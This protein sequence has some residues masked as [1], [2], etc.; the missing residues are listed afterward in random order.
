[1]SGPGAL[2]ERFL[3]DGYLSV[4]NLDGLSAWL[5]SVSPAALEAEQSEDLAQWYRLNDTWFAGVN[6][7]PNDAR[8]RV[9][10]G[11]ALPE[12]VFALSERWY[13]RLPLDRAQISVT[14]PG[15]PG[16]GDAPEAAHRY[17]LHR[18]SAHVDGLHA[19]G[20]A[21]ARMLREPHA[22]VLGIPLSDADVQASP[23]VVWRGSHQVMR[24]ALEP[25]LSDVPEARWAD[26]DLSHPYQAARRR[27]FETCDAE[28]V[29]VPRG[30]A[31]LVHRHALHGVK[32]WASAQT[33]PRR[34]LYFRPEVRQWS[35]WL[36]AP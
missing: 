14:Y 21:R 11:L 32:P 24:A 18:F 26:V 6:A 2:A 3:R 13:G 31:Y 23:M 8:G 9:G 29:H 20:P 28:V 34:I 12:T 7:L 10:D 33:M 25:A 5:D 19:E 35:D 4:D 16:R 27:V 17:R 36:S 1:M 30:G 15:Y 22:F